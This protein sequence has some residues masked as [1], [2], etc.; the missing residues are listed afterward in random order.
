MLM[1]MREVPDPDREE[2]I[3]RLR[4]RARLDAE[5][6]V[7]RPGFTVYGLLAPDLGPGALA[8]SAQ[9][10]GGWELIG[11]AYGDPLAL[12]GPLISVATAAQGHGQ[13]DLG[14]GPEPGGEPGAGGEPGLGGEPG[15]GGEPGLGGGPGAGSEPGPGSRQELLLILDQARNRIADHVGVDAEEPAGP[16][17]FAG[18][19]L[20]VDG[21]VV[22]GMICRHGDLWAGR[23]TTADLVILVVGRG[24]DPGSVQLAAVPD[25]APCLRERGERI[26]RLVQRQRQRPEPVLPPAEGVA[27][28]RALVDRELDW[29]ER[30]RAAMRAG[31]APRH[32]ADDGAIRHALWQRAA[33]EQARISGCDKWQADE[34]VTLVVN[35]LGHLAEQAAWFSA[36]AAL[37]EAAINE[38]L[39]YCVLGEDVPSAPAQ[40]AW[41]SYWAHH[42]APGSSDRAE[43]RL[44]AWWDTGSDL[45]SDW[46]EAWSA[47]AR[48]S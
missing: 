39:R 18:L 20:T 25:L 47:W 11:L 46:L 31:R 34:T 23:L 35:H 44:R 48:R 17:A 30:H 14:G 16:P 13:H 41:A 21:Q 5:E 9:V 43:P 15:A 40:H 45:T 10:N 22:G 36:D 29:Q 7:P 4:E 24:V 27:A 32:T 37:R 19:D 12:S 2:W 3:A 33:R 28:Y 6:L 8:E 38:T 1:G 42:S 26:G